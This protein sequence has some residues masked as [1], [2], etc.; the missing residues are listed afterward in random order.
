MLR[1]VC[2]CVGVHTPGH[3]HSS[4]YFVVLSVLKLGDGEVYEQN[5]SFIINLLNLHASHLVQR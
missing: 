3:P 2:L 5:E 4:N 1:D